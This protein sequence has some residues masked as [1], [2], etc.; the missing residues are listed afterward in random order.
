VLLYW[1]TWGSSSVIINWM[2]L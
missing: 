2:T 1:L